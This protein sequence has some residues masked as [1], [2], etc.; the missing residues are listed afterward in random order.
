MEIEDLADKASIQFT[1]P[2]AFFA[3]S[4]HSAQARNYLPVN[5]LYSAMGA[6]GSW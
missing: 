4:E 3:T 5:I 1:D 2:E 6:F